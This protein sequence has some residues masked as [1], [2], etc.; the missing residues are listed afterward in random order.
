VKIVFSSRPLRTFIRPFE[1]FMDLY[2]KKISVF[3]LGVS[4]RSALKFLAQEGADLSVVNQG[5]PAAWD[6]LAGITADVDLANCWNENA[7]SEHLAQSSLII[8]GP[9]IPRTHPTLRLAHGRGVKIWSEIELAA[10]FCEVPIIAVTGTNGKTTTV[11]LLGEMLKNC[12]HNPFVGGNIGTPFCDFAMQVDRKKYDYV[13]LELS[14]FQLESLE[15]FSPH[16]A[17]LLNLSPS[18]GER[19]AKFSDYARAKFHIADGMDLDDY[20]LFAKGGPLITE[21]LPSVSA[22][23]WKVDTQASDLLRAEILKNY[24]LQSF[25]LLGEHNLVNL[26]FAI[27]ALEFLDIRGAGIQK[28]IDEFRAPAHRLEKVPGDFPFTAY[29]DAKS[30]N[31]QSTMTALAGLAPYKKGLALILGGQF[32]GTGDELGEYL[33]L[34][35]EYVERIFLIG[36]STDNLALE[37]AGTMTIEKSYSLER[38][39]EYCRNNEFSGTLLLSP[40]LPSFDQYANYE[41]RGEHFK[42]LLKNWSLY[43]EENTPIP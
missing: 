20:L 31:W 27:Q 4:G 8:L 2:N 35:G 1:V 37:L 17:I 42:N 16:I 13:V 38:V 26:Y 6:N 5:D 33:P 43:G 11:T 14:S 19:Y 15:N 32:R 25:Q 23:K 40:G 21:W 3:G 28:T 22:Q 39:L 34:L 36:E 41:K 9:G 24:S 29:N 7:A 30:T 12:G 18:H 10:R